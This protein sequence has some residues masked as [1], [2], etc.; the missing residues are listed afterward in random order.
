MRNSVCRLIAMLVLASAIRPCF[1]ETSAVRSILLDPGHTP[2]QPGALGV[3]G[4]YE[5]AYNDE[6]ISKLAKALRAASFAVEL[7]RQ[8]DE[9][10]G[11][12]HR[13]EL[14]NRRRPDIFLSIHHDSAQLTYLRKIRL[15]HGDAYRTTK[16]IAG[17]SI[18]VSKT[19]PQFA[20]S[21]RFAERLGASLI[22]LGRPPTLHHAEDIAGEHRELLN[23]RLGVY[24]FDDLVVLAKT[25]MPAVLLEIGVIVD[26]DDERYVAA[27][28]N[29][30]AMCRRIVEA[31]QA[32]FQEPAAKLAQ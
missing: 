27:E 11:L 17:Y 4:R 16:Q 1:A 25:T 20:N 15:E 14:A 19:N 18:F 31:L 5:V 3:R 22:R 29:Q 12:T 32:Y 8:P 26:A 28:E 6:F 24:R 9:S 30:D 23:E 21:L 13:V 2:R 10:I 7:T